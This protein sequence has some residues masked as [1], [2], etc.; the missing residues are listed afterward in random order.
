VQSNRVAIDLNELDTSGCD[1][2][3]AGW[4]CKQKYLG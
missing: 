2:R 3:S 4:F 1:R